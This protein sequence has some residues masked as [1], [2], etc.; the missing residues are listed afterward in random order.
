MALQ[1]CTECKVMVSTTAKACPH[2]GHACP[3]FPRKSKADQ[4][5]KAWSTVA[6][7]FLMISIPA[8]W[9]LNLSG[10][11]SP[12]GQYASCCYMMLGA[13]VLMIGFWFVGLVKKNQDW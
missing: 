10:K 11:T 13:L 12:E 4:L 8:Y 2:C 6:I 9:A 7:G 1:P 5:G 3:T